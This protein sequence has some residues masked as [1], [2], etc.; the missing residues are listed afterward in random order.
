[1]IF[2]QFLLDKNNSWMWIWQKDL[3]SISPLTDK[4]KKW[5][6]HVF[7]YKLSVISHQKKHYELKIS[8]KWQIKQ[9]NNST[10]KRNLL[11]EF[12]TTSLKYTIAY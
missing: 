11:E 3:K 10:W 1:M 12:M 4:L 7:I 9:Q 8:K 5:R 2:M 6:V